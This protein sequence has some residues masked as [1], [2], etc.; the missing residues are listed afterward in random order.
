MTTIDNDTWCPSPRQMEDAQV[1]ALARALGLP[2]YDALH[3]FS[4][5]DPA[6]YWMAAIDFLGINWSKRPIAY[7][8][9]A[10]GPAFP[11]WFPGGELNWVD[12]VLAWADDPRTA[13]ALG[14]VAEQEDG[15]CRS[16]TFRELGAA[17]RRF[18]AGLRAHG[19]RRGDRVGMLCENGIEATV[20]LLGL[21]Y[22]GAITVPLFSGFG[23]DAVIARLQGG[24]VRALIATTGFYRRGRYVDVV[25]TIQQAVAQLPGI[26]TVFWKPARGVALPALGLA[27]QALADTPDDGQP[28]VRMSPDDPFLVIYTSGTTGKPKGP[29]HTHGGFPLKIAHDAAVH[30]D[31]DVGDVYCWPADIGWVAGV[32]VLCSALLRGA[33]LVCY[34]GAPDFPDWSRMS[35]IV[36]R[37]KV[38]HFGSAPTLIRGMASNEALALAGDRSTVQLLITAGETIAPEHFTWFRTRFG[39]NAAPVINYT[40]GTEVS[41]GLLSSVVVKPI[42]PAGFNTG[43]PGVDVRVVDEAG[44]PLV[45][46]VGELAIAAPFVGMTQ[47]FWQDDERYLDSYWRTTPGLWIH[48]DLAQQNRDGSFFMMGRS[49]DTLKVAGKRLGP[50]EV[51]EIVLELPQV[52]EAAAVGIAD[53]AKGEALVVFVVPKPTWQGD[54]D[55]MAR[56]VNRVVEQRMGKPFR[57]SAVHSVA[58]LPKTRSSKVMRRLIRQVYCDQPL[59]DLSALDNPDA[60][61]EIRSVKPSE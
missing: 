47:S 50:A 41:G 11:R 15:T 34:D 59:G 54:Q 16:L 57:P 35:R 8:D 42:R 19:I 30:F 48:G 25:P 17:V 26:E 51:E 22:I 9:L 3:A 31:V 36:E 14:L 21:S 1:L 10:R 45:G 44:H 61:E 52:H 32:L 5:R 43:S 56:E 13:D 55:E 60:L 28:S 4:L 29:V 12:T 27:W 37:H 6:G 53:A 38:T 20:S 33:T 23:I 18:A 49:D 40:G 24:G 7:I 2:D 39:N 58:S 46:R